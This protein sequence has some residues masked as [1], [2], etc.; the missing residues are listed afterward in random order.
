[1]S[2]MMPRACYFTLV[3][4]AASMVY[5]SAHACWL[6]PAAAA[7]AAAAP[8]GAAAG[9]PAAMHLE[10]LSVVDA[11]Q[12]IACALVEVAELRGGLQ[13][14]ARSLLLAGA[15]ADLVE[16][17]VVALR[18]VDGHHARALQQVRPESGADR[19][20]S[21]AVPQAASAV[22]WPQE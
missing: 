2:Q 4:A 7:A 9:K 11:R 19:R 17:V 22:L 13:V 20:A 12:L 8:A 21:G 1:L 15:I 16:D 10:L 3:Q 18:V 14:P 5:K 6:Q